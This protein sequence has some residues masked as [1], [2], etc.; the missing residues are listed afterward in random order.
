M[1]LVNVFV[2]ENIKCQFESNMMRLTSAVAT[3]SLTS[4]VFLPKN[5][6][7][8]IYIIILLIPVHLNLRSLNGECRKFFV[9]L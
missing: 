8:K 6:Q 2:L 9:S 5:I 3:S 4:F 1:L 7:I